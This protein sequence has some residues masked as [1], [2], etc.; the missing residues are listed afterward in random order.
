MEWDGVGWSGMEWDGVGW[1]GMGWDG[2]GWDTRDATYML[3]NSG[4]LTERNESPHSVASALA[5]NVLPVPC[6]RV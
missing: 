2:M 1:N 4:P 5:I 6:A 3:S